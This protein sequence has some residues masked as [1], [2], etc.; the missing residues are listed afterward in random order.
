MLTDDRLAKMELY[1]SGEN[2]SNAKDIMELIE[3]VKVY[4]ERKSYDERTSISI[5]K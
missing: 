1:Y 5:N 4:R 3:E 2:S